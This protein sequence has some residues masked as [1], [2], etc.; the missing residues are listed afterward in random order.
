MHLARLYSD[1][2]CD[3]SLVRQFYDRFPEGLLQQNKLMKDGYPLQKCLS[4]WKECDADLFIWIAK[5]CPEAVLH[6]QLYGFNVLHS[7]CGNLSATDDDE[8]DAESQCTENMAR[9]CRFLVTEF[10]RLVRV[11]GKDGRGLPIHQLARR[12]NRPLVQEIILLCLKVYPECIQVMASSY[13]PSLRNIPFIRQ[14]LPLIQLELKIEE[15]RAQLTT[16]SANLSTVVAGSSDDM[17]TQVNDI[18]SSWTDEY[19]DT[20]NVSGLNIRERIQE[21][22]QSFEG[23]DVEAHASY[24]SD[25][26]Y[27]NCEESSDDEHGDDDSYLE[28]DGDC[29]DFRISG[30]SRGYV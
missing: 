6:R 13:L 9:I 17:C 16:A 8:E 12:C 14:V 24:E 5:K 1:G 28:S 11:T 30:K 15:E 3:A 23:D 25:T 29:D 18:F 26:A 22:C 20:M 27:S 21:V 10:P 4:G 7:A 19:K 2:D